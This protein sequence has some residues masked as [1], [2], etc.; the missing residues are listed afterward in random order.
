MSLLDPSDFLQENINVGNKDVSA[1]FLTRAA[2][3]VPRGMNSAPAV[4]AEH[5]QHFTMP[6]SKPKALEIS[7]EQLN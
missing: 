5:Q 1:S 2:Y 3:P 4:Q 7:I 6:A